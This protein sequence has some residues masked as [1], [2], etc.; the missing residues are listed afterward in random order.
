MEEPSQ[1]VGPGAAVTPGAE[2]LAAGEHSSGLP[3]D[4]AT[5]PEGEVMGHREL[6][7]MGSR[8]ETWVDA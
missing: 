8:W 2:S 5:V 4:K 6:P 1:R 3:S 7:F